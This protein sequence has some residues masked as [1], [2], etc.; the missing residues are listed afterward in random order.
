MISHVHQSEETNKDVYMTQC[1]DEFR[2]RGGN[3]MVKFNFL[4]IPKWILLSF[5]YI[6]TEKKEFLN[7]VTV[8]TL[9]IDPQYLKK[10]LYKG[11]KS[12]LSQTY[13]VTY[14]NVCEKGTKPTKK[15]LAQS[16]LPVRRKI[17]KTTQK[18]Q[19]LQKII[20]KFIEK[21]H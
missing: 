8:L 13:G 4:M 1:Q 10:S 15:E 14:Q 2:S 21:D 5:R 12:K 20:K 3:Q 16:D 18:D 6:R 7:L 19:F 17:Q 11:Q 9:H